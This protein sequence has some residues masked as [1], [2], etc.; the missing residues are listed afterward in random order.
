MLIPSGF[1]EVCT[2]FR[3]NSGVSRC[4][5]SEIMVTMSMLSGLSGKWCASPLI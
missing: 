1:N 3:H 4:S 2:S 5:I